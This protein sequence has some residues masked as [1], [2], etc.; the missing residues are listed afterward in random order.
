[1]KRWNG[2]WLG[3]AFRCSKKKWRQAAT[4]EISGLGKKDT[5][6]TQILGLDLMV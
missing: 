6:E 3:N 4:T 1:M 2:T 5:E